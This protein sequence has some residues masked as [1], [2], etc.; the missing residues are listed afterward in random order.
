MET[1]RGRR[2]SRRDERT[3]DGIKNQEKNMSME[4]KQERQREETHLQEC[5]EIIR[6]NIERYEKKEKIVPQGSDRIV[7]GGEKRGR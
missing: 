6:E 3:L 2:G 1:G 5:L 4:K 7:S